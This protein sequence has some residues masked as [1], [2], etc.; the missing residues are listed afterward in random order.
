[1]PDDQMKDAQIIFMEMLVE[2]GHMKIIKNSTLISLKLLVHFALNI[3]S[4]CQEFACISIEDLAHA[5]DLSN[6]QFY[7]DY[8]KD[9]CKTIIELSVLNYVEQKVCFSSPL[10]KLSRTFG[11]LNLNDFIVQEGRYL[12]PFLIPWIVKLPYLKALLDSISDMTLV[13]TSELIANQFGNIYPHI[14]IN[15]TDEVYEKCL[16]FLRS[17]SKTDVATLRRKH[18]RVS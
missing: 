16:K 14:F 13:P 6:N 18:F 10:H 15:E 7:I 1:M 2:F 8:K 12:L 17:I 5:L 11:F 9:I 4:T 3:K